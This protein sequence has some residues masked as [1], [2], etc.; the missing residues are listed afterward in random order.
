MDNVEI[1]LMGMISKLGQTNNVSLAHVPG[2]SMCVGNINCMSRTN[3]DPTS[4]K[5][6][7]LANEVI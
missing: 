3:S 6:G 1:Q 4:G 7:H 2:P 5:N